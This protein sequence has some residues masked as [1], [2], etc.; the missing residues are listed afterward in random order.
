M[1]N[2]IA[3]IELI[4]GLQKGDHDALA[5][6]MRMF[7]LSLFDY[8]R[9]MVKSDELVKDAVQEVFLHLWEKR[10][11][12]PVIH[13]LS[14]YLLGAVRNQVIKMLLREKKLGSLEDFYELEEFHIEFS[15]EENLI[16][17]Q[18]TEAKNKLLHSSLNSLSARQ[19]EVIYLRYYQNMD[20]AKI[21]DLL[22]ISPQS[23]YNLLHEAIIRLRKNWNTVVFMKAV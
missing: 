17:Q 13:S 9:R 2:Q 4:D 8:G 3:E 15:T 7:Y 19:K 16:Q 12:L 14:F 11:S 23:V 5:R 21:S 18:N 10:K 6:L 20:P 22:Q 1:R